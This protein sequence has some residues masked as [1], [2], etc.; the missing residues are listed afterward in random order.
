MVM[1]AGGMERSFAGMLSSRGY[2]IRLSPKG[3]LPFD[4]EA[5]I[6][7]IGAVLASVRGDP[8]VERAGPVIAA[9]VHL[10]IRDSLRSFVG[11]GLEPDA[12]GLYQ[13]ESGRDLEPFDSAGVLLGGPAAA[14]T[15]L[16]AGDTITLL[17]RLDPQSAE[18][19]VRRRVVVRGIVRF[20]YDARDQQSLAALFPVIQA[21]GPFSDRDPASMVMV[22][23]R[24]DDAVEALAA[25]IAATNPTIEVNS[26][27]ALVAHFRN[28]LAYFQQLSLILATIA[29][30]VGVLLIG[31]I[32]TITV[33]ERVGE[34]AVLR[35]IGFRR[36]RVVRL[37]LIEGALL[38]VSG[39]VVGVV[40]GLGTA[41]YL[42]VILTSFPGLPAAI[43]FFVPAPGPVARAAAAIVVAGLAAAGY[44]AWLAARAPI[45]ETL[46]ADAG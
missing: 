24:T 43:S 3:T 11:Y 21:L 26:V 7:G 10:W 18:P 33:S 40:L 14:S 28:R 37:V 16:A 22:K 45:A 41:R 39:A 8:V 15:G 31:T 20:L 42:D 27:A 32:L 5:T 29:L 23:A 44:P 4:S 36:A 17:G 25:R 34:F 6:P 38:T 46:R 13:L 19:G 9:P 12:Q 2:Q 30:V 35:G 1:L